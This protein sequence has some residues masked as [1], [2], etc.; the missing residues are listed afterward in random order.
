MLSFGMNTLIEV[1]GIREE[2]CINCHQCISVCPVKICS[3]G[4]GGVV[5]F[6]NQ[7]CIGCGRCIEACIKS[8][9]GVEEKSARFPIDDA[10]LF[11]QNIAQKDIIVLV[12]P[13]AQA[14]F[15]LKKLIAALRC[16]G[17]FKVYDVSL[18]AEIT[19]AG[20]HQAIA[21]GCTP[22]P[23]IAQPCPAVVKYIELHHP[24]L[25]PH[26][27]PVGSPVH[28]LAVYVKSIYPDNE[29]AFISPCLAKRREFQDSHLIQ[30]NVI[31]QSL[32]M[33]FR[34]RGIELGSLPDGNFDNEISAGIATGFSA[35]GGLKQTYLNRYPE[36]PPSAITQIE[37][38]V[39]YSKYLRD[40]ERSIVHGDTDLPLLVDVLNCEKGCNMGAGCVN[41][42]DSIDRVEK[43]VALR[44]EQ[45]QRDAANENR[46]QY[47]IAD[48]LQ[49]L[50][51]SFDCYRNL[52]GLNKLRIPTQTEL[53]AIY[54]RMHKTDDKDF[55]N[56]AACGYHSCYYMAVAVFNGLNKA[57]N[58]H[59]YQEK[60]L[61]SE[62]Q[63]LNDM[64]IELET[65]NEQLQTE[66]NERKAQEQLLVQNCKLAAMGEMIGMIAHQWRQ[67]LSSIST[68]AGNLQ[69]LIEL[70]MIDPEQFI[71][72]L[73][74]INN[75]SQYLSNTINDFR[76]FFKPDNPKDVVTVDS[77]VNSTLGIIGKSLEYKN[78]KLIREYQFEHP[79]MTYPTELMQVFLN[80]I[81]NAVDA[82]V[83]NEI[84]DPAVIIRGHEDARY[85]II[86]IED[87]AGGIPDDI[88]P[89]IFNPYFSTKG[90]ALG[91][92]VGLYMSKMIV[93]EHCQGELNAHNGSQ[94]ACFT[95]KLPNEWGGSTEQ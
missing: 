76:H 6:N 50:D 86:E 77:I 93:E 82:L 73:T 37:G 91:T 15:D 33:A 83:D 88:L 67:P 1:I 31:F 75:H 43:S 47:F 62:R 52:S 53:Q 74:E 59:L 49:R 79:I 78:I 58:C 94:G 26:L 4:S 9:G 16:L 70:D 39:V 80:L 92:G 48:V 35:P 30:Y 10:P 68:L 81:K 44:A 14:N 85:Q 90:P 46:L 34:E 21:E 7:L 2:Y 55:R 95:V 56:C 38:P 40:L 89:Q 13:S 12:A 63:M 8:H 87:N 42:R 72:L 3:D 17:A 61:L 57:E 19:V 18:G 36:T 65:L 71:Q 66:F 27:A 11:L 32:L 45:A 60:E 64:V 84:K 54:A 24:A 69:I 5:K 20:Y 51:F 22:T 25:I 28:N 29:L 41:Y 23:V